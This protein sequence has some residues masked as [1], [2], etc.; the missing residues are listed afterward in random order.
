MSEATPRRRVPQRQELDPPA[1]ASIEEVAAPPERAEQK[2]ADSREI[3]EQI[4]ELIA[5]V[6]SDPTS[7]EGRLARE[8]LTASL[9]LLTDRRTTGELKL[10]TT[11]VK[12]LR[13][14]YRVFAEYDA[15]RVTIFGSA[16]TPPEHPDYV[17]A[18]DFG[19]LMAAAGWMAI[20]GAGGGIMKAG[21]EGPGRELSFGASIR[22]PY[23][24]RANEVIAG[25]EKLVRFR[26]FFTRKLIFLS[27]CDAVA[28][29]PGGFGTMDEA[30]E[31]LTLVQTG[32]A[33]LMPIVMIE[34][35]GERY[36]EQ[37]REF[38]VGRLL[39]RAMISRD[40][41]QLFYIARD[42]ADAVAHITDFYRVYHSSRYVGD[43]LVIRLNHALA[44][45]D[46]ERLGV[47]FADLIAS[48]RLQQR[49]ALPG[50]DDHL[51]LPR[52]V[53]VHTRR[54]YG[55]LRALVDAINRCKP[56]AA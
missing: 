45:T 40:D 50:E 43:R 39:A 54:D 46:V 33:A 48:G 27:Q 21:H 16:R 8:L 2:R 19:R 24:E 35:A 56:P 14:A 9:K 47:E 31:T 1:S 49:G 32:K 4:D 34:G 6:G 29:F 30:F 10:I 25:D 7:Y 55:R 42:P 26:Y 38:I 12:E 52:L 37:W 22:L 28:L 15:P 17:A 36:W 23:E 13:Y 5:E 41:L 44:D 53:F 3:A 20:T 51:D 11:A 18:V